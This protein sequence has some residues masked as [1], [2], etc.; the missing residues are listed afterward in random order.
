VDAE[1][2][3]TEEGRKRFRK[4]IKRVRDADFAPMIVATS[5]LLRCRQTAEIIQEITGKLPIVELAALAPGSDLEA[6]LDWT[7]GQNAETVC[8]VGHAPDV[9]FLA[10]SLVG[11]P[12]AS[13]HF[14]KGSIAAI[15]FSDIP[16]QRAGTLLWHATA[17]LLGC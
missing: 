6:A 4:V 11:N 3:L 12:S 1:R 15:Q 9:E 13:I 16:A 10:G 5:P 17:K 2:P 14:P 7:Q 8:W